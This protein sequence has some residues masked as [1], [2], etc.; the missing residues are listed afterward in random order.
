LKLNNGHL[1]WTK[2]KI[3]FNNSSLLV[4]YKLLFLLLEGATFPSQKDQTALSSGAAVEFETHIIFDMDASL[5]KR[6]PI[7]VVEFEI[8]SVGRSVS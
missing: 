1:L 8:Q 6:R 5:N 2:S 7:L 3:M 4:V